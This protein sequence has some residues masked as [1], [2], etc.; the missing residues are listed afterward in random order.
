MQLT[1]SGLGGSGAWTV[2]VEAQN[3]PAGA[4]VL[5]PA[6]VTVPGRLDLTVRTTQAVDAEATG[7]VV[8]TRGTDRLRIPYWF[9]TGTPALAG[10]KPIA[11]RRTGDHKAST[12]G[13]TTRVTRYRY[14][15]NP[16]GLGFSATLPGPER[17]FRV[18]LTR[19]ATNF[20]VVI[21]SRAPRV[22]VEPRIVH[23]GDERRLTG[24]A[25]LPFNLN[26]YLRTFGELVLAAGTILPAKGSYDVVFDS[27]SA[28]RAGAFTFRY[29][30][31]DVTGPSL[32]LRTPTVKSGSPI[33]LGAAD[34]GSGVDPASVVVR[35]DGDEHEGRFREGAIRVAT[36]GL[37]QGR[38][39][40]RVQI[41]DYQESRNMEN[42]GRILPNTRI[43]QT[44]FVV[45]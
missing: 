4:T 25:A 20:G 19:P 9:G 26:P 7:Y 36:T 13:G 30:I 24:Y 10:A 33:V 6:T 39:A 44:T 2:A 3:R 34:R 37:S 38:H 31:D 22:R 35:I 41:S 17:V 28:A 21:T 23:A 32:R 1:D 16:V 5:A 8:L 42:V 29:W 43:L 12:K 18:T 11:L 45:R 40:L 27:P 15:E 14:P